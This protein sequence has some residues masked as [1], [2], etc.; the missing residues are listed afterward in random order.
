MQPLK[1]E[2]D[3]AVCILSPQWTGTIW[4]WPLSL[5]LMSGSLAGGR[6]LKH[7][8][9]WPQA[10]DCISTTLPKCEGTNYKVTH[11][12]TVWLTRLLCYIKMDQSLLAG[13]I[14]LFTEHFERQS[15]LKVNLELF[16]F[17]KIK[18]HAMMLGSVNSSGIF[19]LNMDIL[20]KICNIK[21]RVAVRTISIQQSVTRHVNQLSV[22]IFEHVTRFY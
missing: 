21:T 7:P 6:G 2:S 1:R 4:P 15:L 22:T 19:A 10:P 9:V 17:F 11:M 14:V 8:W 5:T 13:E 3:H 16:H 18:K 12:I 20:H